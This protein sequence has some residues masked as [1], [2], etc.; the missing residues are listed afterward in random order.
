MVPSCGRRE[1]S[2][3]IAVEPARFAGD[4]LSEVDCASRRVRVVETQD[5][6]VAFLWLCFFDIGIVPFFE[7]YSGM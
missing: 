4:I 5:F 6:F 3:F 1:S 2:S 7:P